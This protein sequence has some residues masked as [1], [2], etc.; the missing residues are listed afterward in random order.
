M[1][2]PMVSSFIIDKSKIMIL[3]KFSAKIVKIEDLHF[4]DKTVKLCFSYQYNKITIL[5]EKLWNCFFLP[6]L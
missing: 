3:K 6:K 1:G 4:S 5:A 2:K